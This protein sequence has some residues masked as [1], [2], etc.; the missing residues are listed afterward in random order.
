MR[1]TA[2]GEKEA[3]AQCLYSLLRLETTYISVLFPCRFGSVGFFQSISSLLFRF[4][5]SIALSSSLLVLSFISSFL[6]LNPSTELFILSYLYSVT[7][8]LKWWRRREETE[9]RISEVEKRTIEIF[10]S[11][12]PFGSSISL[13]KSLI[14]FI[15]FKGIHNCL[16]SIFIIAASK[17]W[18]NNSDVSIILVLVYFILFVF[19]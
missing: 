3:H 1:R 7:Q 11:K 6:L 12:F 4:V 19:V 10:S 8:Q 13:L 14:F 2:N 15:Y 9:E 5:N 17:S 16:L 18:S